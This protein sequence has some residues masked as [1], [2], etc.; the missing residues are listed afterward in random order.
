MSFKIRL[1]KE[2]CSQFAY[3]VRNQHQ[4]YTT[5]GNKTSFIVYFWHCIILVCFQNSP[6]ILEICEKDFSLT[7]C[8]IL[9]KTSF[10]VYVYE[11]FTFQD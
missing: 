5:K 7:K 9:V 10:E 2:T 8:S 1:I 4:K 6:Y 3:C 11:A